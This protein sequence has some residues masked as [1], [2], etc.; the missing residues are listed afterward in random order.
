MTGKRRRP[1]NAAQNSTPTLSKLS[2]S[3]N[4]D[5]FSFRLVRYNLEYF[6]SLLYNFRRRR[7][8]TLSLF[9][10]F[11]RRFRFGFLDYLEDFAHIKDKLAFYSDS[12]SLRTFL[13]ISKKLLNFVILLLWKGSFSI[14]FFKRRGKPN[15]IPLCRTL[16]ICCLLNCFE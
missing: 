11:R 8:L 13:L 1:R 5:T 16:K 4:N 15:N 14:C 6:L 10:L 7:L 9:G 2:T 12:L 3:R